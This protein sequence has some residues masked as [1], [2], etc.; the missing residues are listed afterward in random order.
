MIIASF[1]ASQRKKTKQKQKPHNSRNSFR[2][3][4]L[5]KDHREISEANQTPGTVIQI[6]QSKEIADY[7]V[8]R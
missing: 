5:A 8:P 3:S 2:T 7:T 4:M 6:L 1:E